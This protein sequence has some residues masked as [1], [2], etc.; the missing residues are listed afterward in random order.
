MLTGSR[1][2]DQWPFQLGSA[3]REARGLGGLEGC[4]KK[5]QSSEDPRDLA[6]K[7]KHA[8]KTKKRRAYEMASAQIGAKLGK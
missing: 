6:Q 2:Q 4:P 8:I 3:R 5:S 1:S 7:A